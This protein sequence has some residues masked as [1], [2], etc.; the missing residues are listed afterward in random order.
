MYDGYGIFIQSPNNYGSVKNAHSK[1]SR[2]TDCPP[3]Q[4]Q[5]LRGQSECKFCPIGQKPNA[6]KTSCEMCII[7]DETHDYD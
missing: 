4:Y 2:S 1:I 6:D 3:N 7:S 5:N